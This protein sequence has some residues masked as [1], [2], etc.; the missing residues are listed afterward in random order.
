MCLLEGQ[1]LWISLQADFDLD[2]V[3]KVLE[4]KLIAKFP[5]Y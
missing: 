2:A 4:G 1:R 3:F 5:Q